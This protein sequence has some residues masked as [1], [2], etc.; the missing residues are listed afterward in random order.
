MEAQHT[1]FLVDDDRIF[2]QRMQRYL[3]KAG[4]TVYHSVDSTTAAEA[5]LSRNPDCVLLDI[6]MPG[7][8][9]LELC[10]SLRN[11]TGPNDLTIVII[12]SKTYEFDKKRA[13]AF[14]ADGYITKPVNPDTI[15]DQLERITNDRL[16]L[17]F[18]GIRGTLPVP[19]R[20]SVRYGGNTPCISIEFP[21]GDFFIFDAGSGIKN[22]SDY[23]IKSKTSPLEAK[24]LI[25]HP[26]WD[27]INALPYFAPLYTPGN[28][29][30]I[31][32]PSQTD[33][34]IR[35]LIAGQMD[36]V[37]FPIKIK[38]FGSTITFRD[39]KEES[40]D[41]GSARISTM[42]LHHP[43]YCLGYRVDYKTRSI[44]YI[45]DNE[46]YPKTS[47][48]YNES[49][50]IRL[51]RFI[52]G[53]DVLITDSTYMDHEYENHINWG[54]SPVSRV[55]DLAV[56]ADVKRLCL[57]HHDPDQTDDD[58]DRKLN[59]ARELLQQRKAAV[60]CDAPAETDRLVI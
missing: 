36:G 6:M 13:M 52:Q 10:R 16:E 53:A 47:T 26:H 15:V 9:G 31:L 57:F 14:G 35:D 55:V 44:C 48:L 11:K 42:L 5:I 30:E 24:I 2:I 40:F 7:V 50:E 20:Q 33:L 34:T 29:F 17:I 25:S 12:S 49:Y 19:G 41:L 8:D 56:A 22:L 54:H 23:L 59:T 38:D 37:Y 32:G 21:K 43:G 18:W 27:H 45:T 46:L 51:A 60:H 39:L 4:H 58:I 3:E 28:Q 1:Y